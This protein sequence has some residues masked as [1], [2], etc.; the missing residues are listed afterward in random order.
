M[1]VIDRYQSPMG[2]MVRVDRMLEGLALGGITREHSL[3]IACGDCRYELV[4]VV[5]DALLLRGADDLPRAG[6]ELRLLEGLAR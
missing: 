1:R 5:G 4:G 3:L 2:V 6:D